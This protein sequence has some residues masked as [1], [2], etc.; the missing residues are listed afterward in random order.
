M[1][2][3]LD[4]YVRV[5]DNFLEKDFC[6]ELVENLKLAN[7]VDHKYY[8]PTTQRHWQS[9]HELSMCFDASPQHTKYIEDNL[10]FI[11]EKYVIHDLNEFSWFKSW[12]KYSHIRYN[13]Y[14]QHTKMDRH[15][16]HI[17]TL[18]ENKNSGIP[19][20]SMVGLLNDDFEGGDFI[21]WGDTKIEL[22]AG[23]VIV[24]PSNFLYPHEVT[25]VTSGN[26]FSFVSWAS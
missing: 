6:K 19:I 20:L 23:S 10:W 25:S 2:K 26:R 21:M 14:E 7:W 3:N 16:D 8:D 9:D 12:Q 15:C 1:N 11:L 22:T 4:F 5:Y 17:V 13:K 24:F 18:F